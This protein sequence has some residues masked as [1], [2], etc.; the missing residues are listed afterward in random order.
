M[1]RTV[2]H[3]TH[4][5]RYAMTQPANSQQI[6]G[7]R[8]YTSPRTQERFAS[9]TSII[10]TLDKPA[11]RYWVGKQVAQYA[12]DERSLWLPVA[13][14]DPKA[15]FDM[16][17]GS[18]WRQQENSANLG[19]AVHEAVEARIIGSNVDIDSLPDEVKPYVQNF[20]H[21]EEVFQPQWEMSEAT[22]FSYKY[23]YAGT[24]DAIATFNRP[25]LGLVG[26]YL[27]DWKTG[28]SGPYPDAALQLAAYRHA[29]VVVLP[30]G[31][32]TSLP[33]TDGALVVKIRP[34]SY[35]VYPADVSENTFKFFRHIMVAFKWVNETSKEVLG[36]AI[37]PQAVE[38]EA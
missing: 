18:P 31:T 17:K 38:V 2:G 26:R 19:S 32:E 9:V 24:V 28:K 14:K 20:L 33:E 1:P 34:R 12:V 5:E 37:R 6:N 27:I 29:D 11:L 21:F 10:S 35:E 22:V 30:N 23:G 7:V 4:T 8:Y 36:A 3:I 15:A 13:E 25:D 16:I